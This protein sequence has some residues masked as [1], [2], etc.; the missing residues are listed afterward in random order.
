[1][2]NMI[3]TAKNIKQ[4]KKLVQSKILFENSVGNHK[5]VKKSHGKSNK[6]QYKH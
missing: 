5:K 2:R 6:I 1:M 3:L 4:I